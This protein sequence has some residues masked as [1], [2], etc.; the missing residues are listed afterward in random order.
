MAKMKLLI[1]LLISFCAANTYAQEELSFN[2]DYARFH[3]DSVSAYVEFYYSFN[4]DQLTLTEKNDD[5]LVEA[6]I[7]LDMKA[8]GSEEYFINKD[9]KVS[10]VVRKS[11]GGLTD[12]SLVGVFGLVIPNGVY[13]VTVEGRDFLN[14]TVKKTIKEVI[15]INPLQSDE[16]GISDIQLATGI[17]KEGADPNSIFYKNT[18]EVTPN[19]SILYSQ[20]SPVLFYYSELYNITKVENEKLKLQKVLTN[21][22]GRIVYNTSKEVVSGQN[23]IVEIGVVNLKDYPTDTYNLMLGLIDTASNKAMVTNKKFFLYN[24]GVEDTTL[25]LASAT[26]YMGSEYGVL[27]EEECDDMFDKIKYI[28]SGQEIDQ[29][30]KIDSVDAKRKYLFEFWNRRDNNPNQ[31]GN[32]FKKTYMNR[33]NYVQGNFG[34]SYREGYKTDRGRVYLTYGEPDQID[35]YPNESEYKPFEIWTY[36][37]I[38]SGVEFIFGDVTGF[39]SYELLHSTKRGE[40]RDDS[41]RRRLR[42]N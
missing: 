5:F 27:S 13:D 26:G 24:P 41:W 2:F 29:Y 25:M 40:L 14:E 31:P 22:A 30:E 10:N 1:I 15:E 21:S 16:L 19:P 12:K 9:W 34:N 6:I 39:S 38:E 37:G 35:R 7:H 23:S 33:L 4:Q 42:M 3:Y 8:K 20:T 11:T 17:K 28:A 36:H 18:L 32:S